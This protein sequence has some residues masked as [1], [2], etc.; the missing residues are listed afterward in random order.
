MTRRNKRQ[1]S[2]PPTN[3]ISPQPRDPKKVSSI[4]ARMI[5]GHE[6]RS[7][8]DLAPDND[9]V[10]TSDLRQAIA[11]IEVIRQRPCIAYVANMM[12]PFQ[13]SGI[14][15]EDHL[16]FTEMVDAVPSDAP[17]VDVFLVTP[18]GSAEQVIQFV[19]ALRRKF[20]SV[21]FILPYK[22]M[23]AG[24]LWAIS[25]ER[26]WMD[27]RA[28]LGPIDPQVPSKDGNLVPLQSIL[29]IF[30]LLQREG[31]EAIKN[32]QPVPWAFIRMI[33]QMDPKQ[34]GHAIAF[35]DY[36]IGLATQ[37]LNDY[38]F[39]LWTHR[40]DSGEE[41]TPEYRRERAETVARSMVSHDLWKMHGHA[42]SREEALTKLA[43]KVDKIEEVPG[44]QRAVRRLW[45]LFYYIFDKS[46]TVKFMV[47]GNYMFIRRMAQIEIVQ[48]DP[49]GG[50]YARP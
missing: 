37:Y 33:D 44:L 4:I 31:Q 50:N 35:T 17:G 22:A 38:K 20:E 14:S 6:C 15:S 29:T 36:I 47:S 11:D 9:Q 48:R 2:V 5:D 3:R 32:N 12:K 45:A 27:E 18:G 40:S 8:L 25:G 41:V 34:L 30:N 1:R 43:I 46:Q 42:I 21:E 23:S 7:I 16:P 24:T 10:L 49:P 28:Y 39:R 19:D 13:D 26:I